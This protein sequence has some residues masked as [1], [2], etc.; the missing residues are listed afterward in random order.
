MS[1]KKEP[2]FTIP[3]VHLVHE[4]GKYDSDKVNRYWADY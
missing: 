4:L 1:N 2:H 3:N